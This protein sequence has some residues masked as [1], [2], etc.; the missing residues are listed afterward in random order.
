[1]KGSRLAAAA[2]LAL[3]LLPLLPE[4]LGHRLLVFRDAFV[5]HFPIKTYALA[6]ERSGHVPYL[7]A[8]ASNGEPLLANPNTFA[9]YPTNLLYFLLPPATAFN[10]HLLFHLVWAFWGAAFLCRRL[11]AERAASVVG[12]AAYAFSGPYLSYASAFSNSAA[13]AAWAPWALAETIGLARAAQENDTRRALG[14]CLRVSTA[15]GLQLLAGEPAISAWTAGLAA[16][17]AL[18]ELTSGA[19]RGRS[20][21]RFLLFGVLAASLG[22]LLTA[23]QIL[24]TA[25]AFPD[26]FRGGHLFSRD[27]FGAAANVPVRLLENLFPL[28][29]GSP[30]PLHSGAFWGYRLFDSLQPYLYSANLG[31]AGAVLIVSAFFLVP[32]RRSRLVLL[33]SAL[34]LFF[35]LL[36]FGF[37]TPLF[38]LLYSV[39]QLRHFRYPV[40][41]LLPVAV[42]FSVLT[43]LASDAWRRA[44]ALPP[45]LFTAAVVAV[46]LLGVGLL[47]LTRPQRIGGWIAA[48]VPALSIR[49]EQ[50]VPGVL[51]T[52]LRDAAL[53][54][55]ALA[56]LSAGAASPAVRKSL[57]FP[58]VPVLICLIP[59]GW[60]LFV[61]VET[62][63]Y[64][65]KPPLTSAVAGAG[66]LYVAPIAE[67]AV[68]R[69]G[70][71]HRFLRD[72]IGELI[73][74]GRLEL[75]PLTGLPDGISYAYDLDPDGSYGYVDRVV[76]E[77][78]ARASPE[79]KAALLRASSVCF[80][81]ADSP[82]LLPGFRPRAAQVTDG[83][84]VF[85][86]EA[87]SPVPLVRA[88]SRIYR[89][90]S[91]SPGAIELLKSPRFHATVDAVIN[92][93]DRDP[94][95]LDDAR[96]SVSDIQIS[97]NRL[98]AA[99]VG[100]RACLAVFAV[101]Y[102]RYWKAFVDG[103]SARVQLA[104]G[105]FCGVQVPPGAHRVEMSYDERPFLL[106][107]L[108]TFLFAAAA[109]LIALSSRRRPSPPGP[110]G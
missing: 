37:R 90:S 66:R 81:L 18:A 29:F 106:G 83:R 25:A 21:A 46:P 86:S 41:F 99:I 24:S 56:I 14:A 73:T 91:L 75:W 61:S 51:Q 28:A 59:A 2:V 89:R 107:A 98:S 45:L 85:L 9:L 108:G 40:K 10:F 38:D 33:L 12:G 43:A 100:D 3:F 20:L 72:D 63:R 13:A 5:T 30:R 34:V 26:S 78:V 93:P 82:A 68:A 92:G 50:L 48:Q 88:C 17:L 71:T 54:L 84:E 47:C 104:N 105:N 67:F 49:P 95:D 58:L 39:R 11:G 69:F 87:A 22:A 102:F 8:G 94:E 19:R 15:F 77:A 103:Q 16:P 96:S 65:K 27:Q 23:P 44:S 31:L 36:S 64:L 4:L 42:C 76:S 97:P 62:A 52:L 57:S 109:A 101:T 74:A 1:V 35:L 80:S 53:G 70:T 110:T 55:L 6:I 60:P 79:V 32:F 7:N